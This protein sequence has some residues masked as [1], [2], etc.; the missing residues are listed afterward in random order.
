LA[1]RAGDSD[2]AK[3][4]VLKNWP[5]YLGIILPLVL[6]SV[7]SCWL[8]SL[9]PPEASP[10][11]RPNAWFAEDDKHRWFIRIPTKA[12]GCRWLADIQPNA[13][14]SLLA[15]PLKWFG[16]PTKY[17]GIDLEGTFL[18]GPLKRLNIPTIIPS[19]DLEDIEDEASKTWAEGGLPRTS[20]IEFTIFFGL[21]HM[22]AHVFGALVFGIISRNRSTR[23]GV[24]GSKPKGW[25]WQGLA[26]LITSFISGA[27]GGF[28][29]FVMISQ[30]LWRLHERPWAIATVGPP[31]AILVFFVA[32][33]VEV[34]LLG[35]YQ[36]EDTRE[37]WARVCALLL[38]AAVAWLGVM[39]IIFY[40]PPLARYLDGLAHRAVTPTLVAGWIAASIGGALSGRSPRTDGRGGGNPLFEWLGRVAPVVFLVGLLAAVSVLVEALTVVRVPDAGGAPTVVARD[41]GGRAAAA[42]ADPGPTRPAAPRWTRTRI[43]STRRSGA[44]ASGSSRRRVCRW[45]D[46]WPSACSGPGS[47]ASSPTPT[48]SRC[49]TSTATA[50]CGATSGPRGPSARGASARRHR[51]ATGPSPPGSRN[52]GRCGGS[53]PPA[54]APGS[55][56]RAGRRRRSVPWIAPPTGRWREPRREDSARVRQENHVTGFDLDDDLP[57]RAL[58]IGPDPVNGRAGP[59]YYGPYPL[60]NTALNLVAGKELAWQDRKGESFTFTPLF[61]G[62]RDTWYRRLEPASDEYLTLGQAVAISGAAADPNM[63][64]HQSAPLT[65]LM[66]VFNA[67]LGWWLQNPRADG[68]VGQGPGLAWPLIRELLGRTDERSRYVHLSDGGHFENL[69]VYELIRRRCRYVVVSDAGMDS[70]FAFEDLARLIRLCLIDFGIRIEID[71]DALRPTAAGGTGRWHCAIGRIRYDDVDGGE[72][73]GTLI[74][75]KASLTGDEPPDVQNY[76]ALHPE[77]PHQSTADQFFDEDQFESYRMLGLHVGLT[78]FK[79]AA[80][81]LR[82]E[83]WN[84][85]QADLEFIRGNRKL[86]SAITRRWASPPSPPEEFVASNE[87]WR[88]LQRDLREHGQLDG[89]SRDIYPE[90]DAGAEADARTRRRTRTQARRPAA[91]RAELHAV[92]QMLQ[93]MEDTW[94]RLDLGASGQVPLNRGWMSVF[95]RWAGTAA[96]HRHW[97]TL[98]SEFGEDFVRFCE[99]QLHLGIVAG[100]VSVGAQEWP[101][102]FAER[103]VAFLEPEFT[104]EWP[105]RS[106]RTIVEAARGSW[107]GPGARPPWMWV[108]VQGPAGE[109]LGD[110]PAQFPIGIVSARRIEGSTI[111]FFVWFRRPYRSMGL[112]GRCAV[113][114]L[115]PL[116]QA[117][118]A[119]DRAPITIQVTFPARPSL[120]VDSTETTGS[121]GND[122][123]FNLWR[124][125]FSIFDFRA[126]PRDRV[127]GP[128]E[129]VVLQ[130]TFD[131]SPQ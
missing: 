9:N 21:L 93:V 81:E 96:F 121:R 92:A 66:T 34:W 109:P 53:P 126:E 112:G 63:G 41:V 122:M 28:L 31:L 77:F 86:F 99:S 72:I 58:A 78:V 33:T 29:F 120:S 102:P 83:L 90:L 128:D 57:L 84:E 51:P 39:G 69:G 74:Y 130:R 26:L 73:P 101:D 45:R 14:G 105:G 103:A 11:R 38:I 44:S 117:I 114:I 91:P 95:R 25:W 19:I 115:G 35:R 13:E 48:C 131:P 68:W 70:A 125:F 15:G 12:D 104:R 61:C 89:L 18:A 80:H 54:R 3:Q 7:L 64:T 98:R 88:E 119:R 49:T 79:E 1:R 62:S 22:A 42:P 56:A 67:R 40:L 107:P 55:P 43:P 85:A 65:A 75:L 118:W 50:W 76:R 123:E 52:S 82:N 127:F 113:K 87:A 60:I 6:C 46:G 2:V 36:N 47:P 10:G 23:P 97:P 8:F 20:A 27:S 94:V 30:V 17:P 108:I 129:D 37:W 111:E 106:L 71:V 110:S 124:N 4:P 16:I 100:P 32:V 116:C 59:P 24:G 5:I